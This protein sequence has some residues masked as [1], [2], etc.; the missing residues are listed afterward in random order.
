VTSVS[1]YRLKIMAMG[2][3]KERMRQ[4]RLWTPTAA[5]P[6]GA[7]RLNRG[8][9]SRLCNKSPVSYPSLNDI[10]DRIGEVIV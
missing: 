7:R 2:R 4:E 10:A 9:L 5:L 8:I 1:F 6:V 3:R